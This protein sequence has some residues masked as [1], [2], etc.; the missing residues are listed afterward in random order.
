MREVVVPPK[1][2]D[3]TRTACGQL[4]GRVEPR[5]Q[6]KWTG[7]TTWGLAVGDTGTGGG[8]G[9]RLGVRGGAM[10]LTR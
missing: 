7:S 5:V 2:D 3:L 1:D 8:D 4:H 9:M 10:V 6:C